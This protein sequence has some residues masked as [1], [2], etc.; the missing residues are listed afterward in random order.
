LLFNAISPRGHSM[1]AIAIARPFGSGDVRFKRLGEQ[2]HAVAVGQIL[3]KLW[4]RT[5][6]GTSALDDG[7]P[8]LT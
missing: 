4:P 3:R 1:F 7:A 5:P 2:L 8:A 6:G